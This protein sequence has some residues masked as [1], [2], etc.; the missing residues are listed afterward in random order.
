M[1]IAAQFALFELEVADSEVSLREEFPPF[2][3][4]QANSLGEKFGIGGL[5]HGSEIAIIAIVS[6]TTVFLW[7]GGDQK[8]DQ[9]AVS[10]IGP[11]AK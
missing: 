1:P 9:D 10:P 4:G 6:Y 11:A 2:L 3:A 8:A 5:T 7:S